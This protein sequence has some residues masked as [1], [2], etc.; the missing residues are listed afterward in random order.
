MQDENWPDDSSDLNY[1]VVSRLLKKDKKRRKTTGV[2][3]ISSASY[4]LQDSLVSKYLLK[5]LSIHSPTAQFLK[6]GHFFSLV[7]SAKSY[8]GR[9]LYLAWV[10]LGISVSCF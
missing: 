7:T 3:L 9:Q 10:A 6:Q 2:A 4:Q 5:N 1:Q 8:K